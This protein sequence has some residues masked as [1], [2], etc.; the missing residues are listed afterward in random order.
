MSVLLDLTNKVLSKAAMDTNKFRILRGKTVQ[1]KNRIPKDVKKAKQRMNKIHRR[2]K[3]TYSLA[4]EDKLKLFRKMY[5]QVVR[6]HNLKTDMDRD[7]MLFNIM[8]ES[9]GKVFRHIKAM[10]KAGNSL[11]PKLTVGQA[12]YTGESVAD[13]F[14]ES[15]SS[16]KRCDSKSL[17][18]VPELSEK[19]LDY[20][21]VIE[22]CRN[23]NGIPSIDSKKARTHSYIL[24]FLGFLWPLLS[25]LNHI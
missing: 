9:P 13:G 21:T 24:A 18:S 4:L 16:L 15:M 22:L 5:H 23:H 25:M 14:F 8:G 10:K 6:S 1:R 2:L 7:I 20:N 17:E 11:V 3:E 19:L 12:V